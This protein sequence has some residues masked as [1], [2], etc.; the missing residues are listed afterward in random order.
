MMRDD[1]PAGRANPTDSRPVPD[2]TL[3][4]TAQLNAAI[5]NLEARINIKIEGM[6]KATDLRLAEI[7]KIPAD[8]ALLIGHLRELLEAVLTEKFSGV[9]LQF[10]ERDVRT[11]NDKTAS[12]AALDA[13][14]R[15]AKELGEANNRSFADAAQKAEISF[16]K[17]IDATGVLIAANAKSAEG[18]I[19]ELKER[20][21][22][23]EGTVNGAQVQRTN[24]R[25]DTG[26]VMA[27]VFGV[28]GVLT[29]IAAIVI[30]MSANGA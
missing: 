2:P 5:G 28:L 26:Q 29:A 23:G 8:T 15:A 17:Q 27:I 18:Q 6:E 25:L 13:A 12:S 14:L 24:Q 1:E 3:L 9:Q 10:T 11:Q 30:S 19:A 4:T 20:I 16:T 7:L 22:R 21:G